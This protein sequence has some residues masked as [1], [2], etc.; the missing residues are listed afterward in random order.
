MTFLCRWAFSGLFNFLLLLCLH[1]VSL[2][3]EQLP[4]RLYTTSD[5][6]VQNSIIRIVRDSRGFLWFC[7]QDG[8]SRFDGYKFTN[9]GG[10]R[11]LPHPNITHLLEARDGTYW[12]ATN[13]GGVAR[14]KSSSANNNHPESNETLF[15]VYPVGNSPSTNRVNVLYQ[16]RAG[17]IW[18][19]T[20]GEL[21]RLE[22]EGE[23]EVFRKV[24]L[25]L[26]PEHRWVVVLAFAEDQQGRLWIGT[27][28]GLFIRSADGHITHYDI[29][30][31]QSYDFV[32]ALLPD[33]E[34][35][36]WVGH[37]G[38]GLIECDPAQLIS[39]G[40]IPIRNDQPSPFPHEA[41]RKHWTHRDGGLTDDVVQSLIQTSDGKIWVGSNQGLSEFVDGHFRS[42]TSAE[43]IKAAPLEWLVED[44]KGDLWAATSL[45]ALKIVRNGFTIYTQVDG[46]SGKGVRAV[47]DN[48]QSELCVLTNDATLNQLAGNRIH[49]ARPNLPAEINLEWPQSFLQDHTG[50]WWMPTSSGLNHFPSV[51]RIDDL[52]KLSPK[53]VYTEKNGLPGHNVLCV[54]EDSR[55]DI[56]ISLAEVRESIIRWERATE[57]FHTYSEP[58][59]LLAFSPIASFFEDRSGAV[60][61]GKMEGGLLRYQNGAFKL[62]TDADGL[63]RGQIQKLFFDQQNRLWIATNASGLGYIED[64]TA[65]SIRFKQFNESDGLTSNNVLSITD[66]MNGN[67]YLGTGHGVDRLDAHNRIIHYTSSEGLI[68]GKVETAFR[69]QAGMLW[70]GTSQGL[71]RFNPS[72]PQHNAPPPVF[73]TGINVAGTPLK[74]SE[75]GQT[76]VDNLQFPHT[77]NQVLIEFAGIAFGEE[78]RYQ[79]KLDGIDADWSF[80]NSQRSVNYGNMKPGSYRFLVRAVT[81]N[82]QISPQPASVNFRIL[83]P[84]WQRPWFLALV[85]LA[86]SLLAYALY[87]YRV[88]QILALANVRTRIAT[89][90]HDDIGAN[91]TKIAILSEVLKQKNNGAKEL[92]DSLSSIADLSRESVASMSDIVWAINPKHDNLLDLTRRMRRHADELFTSRDIKLNFIAPAAEQNLRLGVDVRRDL[93]LIFKEAVNNAARHAQC[94]SVEIKLSIEGS[95][96]ILIIADNG[97]GFDKQTDEEGQGLTSIMRR[98][99]D[100][101]GGTLL[102]ESTKGQGTTV[103]L[104]MPM[105]R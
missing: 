100:S 55:G 102:I 56:W 1:T 63:P 104:K 62:F 57:T 103:T 67:L 91:L 70:F 13:G 16:D 30:P 76:E 101:L 92:D 2:H 21:F 66:D 85:A 39:S 9:Y 6:L 25:G 81:A 74:I 4:T 83:S 47:F 26:P 77:Q 60:W 105:P 78:L 50:E 43:G 93:F 35:R 89:D 34:G 5:G 95:W 40:Q 72:L 22:K 32:R 84:L 51:D 11:G 23:R 54:F 87:R 41:I 19:G 15:T 58:E 17:D 69:D 48:N 42:L 79:Y 73:I 45:G 98:A 53:A 8:L 24:E 46:L 52:R 82:G 28:Q 20:D 31:A 44:I 10:A 90:L 99:E 97:I 68:D 64:L 12:I 61:M 65:D 18:A 36:M 75:L 29:Q 27:W 33:A 96:L 38:A 86:I 88:A 14:L 71:A 49:S 59:D 80:L 94:T 3:S 7:T 37:M